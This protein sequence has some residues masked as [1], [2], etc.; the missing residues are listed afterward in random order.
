M[1]VMTFSWSKLFGGL[2]SNDAKNGH[3]FSGEFWLRMVYLIFS[4]F[5][6]LV[7]PTFSKYS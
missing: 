4:L 2:I 6:F 1:L 3:R 7:F 5:T